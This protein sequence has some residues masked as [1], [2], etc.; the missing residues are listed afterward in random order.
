MIKIEPYKKALVAIALVFGIVFA[1]PNI[2]PKEYRDKLPAWLKPVTLGL[3]LQGG[4]HLVLEVKIDDVLKEQT[5]GLSQTIRQ[6]LREKKIR[7][8]DLKAND[9]NVSVKISAGASLSD[10]MNAVR[11][12]DANSLEVKTGPENT[13]I[14]SYNSIYRN[15]LK[16]NAVNQSIEIVRRRIDETGTR[17]PSIQAQGENRIVVQLPGVENPEM[18]KMMLGKT[19]KL[20]FHL[21]DENTSVLDARQGRIGTDLMLVQSADGSGEAALV[22]QRTP[23]IGGDH[24]VKAEGTFDRSSGQPVVAFKFDTF[25]AKKFGKATTENV[26]NRLAI[27]LDKKVISAPRINSAITGG[28]GTITG[29][30][31]IQS[32]HELGLLLSA[33]ALPAPLEV[34]EERTVGPGLGTDSI[35]AGKT[36]CIIAVIFVTIF[37]VLVYGKWGLFADIALAMNIL[38]LFAILSFIGATLTLPGIAGIALTL[39]M[40]VDANILIYER[41]REEANLGNRTPL[42]IVNAGYQNAFL[43]IVDSNLTTLGAGLVLF[44]FGS[45]PIRG[46]AV[47]LGIGILISMFTAVLGSRVI[48][49]AF[50]NR[51]KPKTITI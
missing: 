27:I 30:F 50:I 51:F 33:G 21:V 36:A 31:T 26:G 43:P 23:V 48:I 4:S 42:Q 34:L 46:F 41:M 3:D 37:M 49:S 10:A 9:D 14:A 17:E 45:G 47:T 22:V 8:S 28:E 20:S 7:F 40:A 12:I 24:L 18:I 32:A 5:M 29:N 2:L 6:T 16:H 1:M 35:N 13:L 44:M 38:L 11:Q 39:G 15:Q 25:G 19:A